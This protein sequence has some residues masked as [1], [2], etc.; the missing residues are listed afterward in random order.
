MKPLFTKKNGTSQRVAAIEVKMPASYPSSNVTYGSGSVEDALD[1][2]FGIPIKQFTIASNETI[3]LSNVFCVMLRT[4]G[5][6]GGIHIINM[7][8]GSYSYALGGTSTGC[9]LSA[10][11]YNLTITNTN[12][13]SVACVKIM[14]AV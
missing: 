2:L 10:S 7:G 3:T 13:Y 14:N 12:A 8:W 9:T 1:D 4:S 11:G 6:A 5:V